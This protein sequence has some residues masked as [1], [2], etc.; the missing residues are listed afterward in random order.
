MQASRGFRWVWV[1]C[2]AGGALGVAGAP[3]L[4]WDYAGHHAINRM[5]L[6][7]LATNFPSF[8]RAP[9]AAERVAFLAG[10]PDR[11]RNA[12][13][14]A[15][16]HHNA[17]DHYID[18]DDLPLYGLTPQILSPFRYEF[19]AQTAIARAA[20]PQEFPVID[21]EKNGDKTRQLVGFL[22]WTI[23]EWYVRLKSAFGYLKVFEEAGSAE[24]IDNAR[25]NVIY[26]MGVLGHYVGD[27]G[28]PLHTT[29]H[30]NGWVGR[31]PRGY[32]TNRTFHAWI[33]GG[34]FQRAG[35]GV[36]G[37]EVQLRK[38]RSLWP[39]RRASGTR[40]VFALTVEFLVEQSK[41]VEPLYELQKA[42]KLSSEGPAGAEGAAVLR[43]QLVK[44][45]QFLAD[46]WHSAWIEAPADNYLRSQLA[47]QKLRQEESTSRP[48][49]SP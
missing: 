41:L 10:E 36:E 34:F 8:V 19:I 37:L 6:S 17:P 40:D 38:A 29:K 46:L 7:A 22:P 42:G 20:A 12:Q 32:T 15:F 23:N 14:L 26:A 13:D 39:R 1:A 2:L 43:T 4:A 5:A 45:A 25:A 18:L 44:S 35:W 30:F 48:D 27:A 3:A 24:E 11:W 47:K 16:K 21:P 49:P 31:N 33:D 9:E 28:Q